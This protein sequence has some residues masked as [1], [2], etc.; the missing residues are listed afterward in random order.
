M[1]RI[2]SGNLY[3]GLRV[4]DDYKEGKKRMTM[5]KTLQRLG[6]SIA[7]A[8]MLLALMS[9][10]SLAVGDY[11]CNTISIGRLGALQNRPALV[12]FVRCAE[13]HVSDVGW[14]QAEDDFHNDPRWKDGAMYLYA[15]DTEG[16]LIFS[17]SGLS[18]PGDENDNPDRVDA[19]GKMHRR[20]M[21]YTAG[22]FGSG[23]VT[24]R[25]GNPDTGESSP[26]VSYVMLAREPYGERSAIL[27]AGFYPT[28]AP[29]TCNPARVR[30][31]LVYTRTDVE[32]FVRCAELELK[33]ARPGRFARPGFSYAVDLRSHLHIPAGPRVPVRDCSPHA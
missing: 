23:F 10:P 15:I 8:G 1:F 2:A 25:F 13:Q 9:I 4:A 7:V 33:A 31:S 11:D 19:D 27:G 6:Q 29:G 26:K 21:M 18:A 5:V 24:Y 22:T 16:Y 14:T 20:R 17:A 28:V 12:N 32:Q 30:S 3:R